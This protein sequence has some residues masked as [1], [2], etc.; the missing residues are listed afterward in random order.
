MLGKR[1][2]LLTIM[3]FAVVD[4]KEAVDWQPRVLVLGEANRKVIKVSQ[5]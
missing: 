2:D 5:K 4:E 3:N 1:G